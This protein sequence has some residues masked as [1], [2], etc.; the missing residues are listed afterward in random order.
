MIEITLAFGTLFNTK[1]V[2]LL[3]EIVEAYPH[4][5]SIRPLVVCSAYVK[6]TSAIPK[7][8]IPISRAT[9]NPPKKDD[10]TRGPPGGK[11]RSSERRVKIAAATTTAMAITKIMIDN[12]MF[13]AWSGPK[14]WRPKI[15]SIAPASSRRTP[16]APTVGIQLMT[17]PITSSIRPFFVLSIAVARAVS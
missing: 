8:A 17:S 14:V 5:R 10:G 13:R 3:V 6:R 2:R 15:T 11:S 12:R 16:T 9:K 1:N 7:M 4:Q